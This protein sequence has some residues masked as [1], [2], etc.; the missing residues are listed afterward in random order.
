VVTRGLDIK[1]KDTSMIFQILVYSFVDHK[2]LH[3]GHETQDVT[4]LLSSTRIYSTKP[5]PYRRRPLSEEGTLYKY[6]YHRR[7]SAHAPG[8]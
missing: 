1:E 6:I 4:T 7:S 8:K 2:T 5:I 3:V